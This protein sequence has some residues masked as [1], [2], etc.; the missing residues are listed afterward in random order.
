MDVKMNYPI[1]FVCPDNNQFVEG[2]NK[3]ENCE[4]GE[5]CLVYKY[6]KDYWKSKAHFVEDDI[7]AKEK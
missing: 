1:K 2:F 4:K 6:E 3:C 5:N 7:I